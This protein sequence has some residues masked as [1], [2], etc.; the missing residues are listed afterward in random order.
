MINIINLRDLIITQIDV[1]K[2]M[3]MLKAWHRKQLH[4]C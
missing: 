2:I 1:P 4:M 3:Q